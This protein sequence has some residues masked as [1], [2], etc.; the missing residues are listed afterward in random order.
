VSEV[1]LYAGRWSRSDTARFS[2]KS[3]GTAAITAIGAIW[4]KAVPNYVE[5]LGRW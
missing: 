1:S 4:Q 5:N 3:E 2:L